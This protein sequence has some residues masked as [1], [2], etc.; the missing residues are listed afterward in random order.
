MLVEQLRQFHLPYLVSVFQFVWNTKIRRSLRSGVD[1]WGSKISNAW[2]KCVTGRTPTKSHAFLMI[3]THLGLHEIPLTRSRS[4]ISRMA[5]NVTHILIICVKCLDILTQ[6]SII[7]WHSRL[8]NMIKM[9]VQNAWTIG[10]SYPAGGYSTPRPLAGLIAT[11]S[12]FDI[13]TLTIS[14]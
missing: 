4:D 1:A 14:F 11:F 6:F 3:L 13:P 9:F 5:V 12:G 7:L 10:K 8:L 2:G